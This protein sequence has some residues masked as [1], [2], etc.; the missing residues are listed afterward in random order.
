M[1]KFSLVLMVVL[2]FAFPAMAIEKVLTFEWDANTESY[3]G[4]YRLYY[5]IGKQGGPYDGPIEQYGKVTTGSTVIEIGPGETF[6]FV[7]TAFAD[8]SYC[9]K[10]ESVYSNEVFFS[11]S[12]DDPGNFPM[13]IPNFRLKSAENVSSNR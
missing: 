4:G 7:L 11:L 9:E 13:E 3:L 10:C 12:P 5:S 1:K 6:Y 2:F 8:P